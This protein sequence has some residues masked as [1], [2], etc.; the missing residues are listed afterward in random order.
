[1]EIIKDIK[2]TARKVSHT[3][4]DKTQ[5][6]TGITKSPSELAKRMVEHL[7]RGEYQEVAHMLTT[8]VKK[9]IDKIDIGNN[10]LVK[11]KLKEFEEVADSIADDLEKNDYGGLINELEKLEESIPNEV[12]KNYKIF[13]ASK[14]ILNTIIEKLKKHVE[15]GTE[16]QFTK[17]ASDFEDAFKQFTDQK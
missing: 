4:V 7:T 3:V 12:A 9:Y 16:P 15:K 2:D 17:L 13:K 5:E 6:V 10:D 8:E 11:T 1:M 14:T